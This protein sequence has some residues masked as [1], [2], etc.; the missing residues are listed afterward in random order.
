MEYGTVNRYRRLLLGLH[1]NIEP[2]YGITLSL[3]YALFTGLMAQ[4]WFYAPWNPHV[5]Y[6]MQVFAVLLAPILLGMRYGALSQAFYVGLGGA[7]LPLFAG[8]SSGVKVLGGVTGGYIV[9]FVAASALI[10]WGID[11]L[12]LK[13]FWSL[14]ILFMAGVGLIYLLGVYQL[15]MW[16][17]RDWEKAWLLGAADF[18]P[19][20][21]FK[22]VVAAGIAR[23]VLPARRR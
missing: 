7:G 15:G 21:L 19:F 6:T 2:A 18:L 8:L 3:G 16:L 1:T 11:S 9:G 17:G 5:P 10:G 13:R 22:A 4:V 23:A 12:R 20:D 14:L